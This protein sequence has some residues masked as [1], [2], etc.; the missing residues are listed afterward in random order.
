MHTNRLSSN[1][2]SSLLFELG[3]ALIGAVFTRARFHD[4]QRSTSEVGVVHRVDRGLGFL[5]IGH[6]NERETAGAACFTVEDD[7]G[8]AD[9]AVGFEGFLQLG[10]GEL[11]GKVADIQV[12]L[13]D[14]LF[15]RHEVHKNPIHGV[16]TRVLQTQWEPRHRGQLSPSFKRSQAFQNALF[17]VPGSTLISRV[18][19]RPS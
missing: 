18:P 2:L 12:H 6:L 15:D 11:I 7:S 17:R 10:I 3:L 5:I 16:E 8:V 13:T 4:F 19:G 14:F 1:Y 9:E